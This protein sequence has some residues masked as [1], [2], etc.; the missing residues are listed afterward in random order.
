MKLLDV[1][2]LALA[3]SG[4]EDSWS[5]LNASVVEGGVVKGLSLE[6]LLGNSGSQVEMPVSSE[7]PRGGS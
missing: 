7:G 6:Q 4:P 1:A 2:R 3:D 5:S